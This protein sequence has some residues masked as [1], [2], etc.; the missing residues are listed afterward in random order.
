MRGLHCPLLVLRRRMLR[1][2]AHGDRLTDEC[3]D[4]LAVI[5]IP[6]LLAET[7]ATLKRQKAANGRFIFLIKSGRV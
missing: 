2:L 5:V 4:P 7:S 3:T 1:E 6:H